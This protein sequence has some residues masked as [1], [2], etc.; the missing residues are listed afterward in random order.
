MHITADAAEVAEDYAAVLSEF[1]QGG[2]K[3]SGVQSRGGAFGGLSRRAT[4]AH[5]SPKCLARSPT[6]LLT[7]CL[8]CL[9]GRSPP[10]EDHVR[11]DNHKEKRATPHKARSPE[12]TIAEPTDGVSAISLSGGQNLDKALRDGMIILGFVTR[13]TQHEG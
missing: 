5:R 12:E 8:V 9:R 7:C 13:T 2:G 3:G 1:F 6:S 11:N 10:S 4:T